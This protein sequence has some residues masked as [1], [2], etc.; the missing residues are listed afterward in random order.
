LVPRHGARRL[1]DGVDVA[2]MDERGPVGEE[3]DIV[4]GIVED[5]APV[6]AGSERRR[7]RKSQL[8]VTCAVTVP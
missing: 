6:G 8:G 7:E 1:D 3:G 5:G 2:R 4:V